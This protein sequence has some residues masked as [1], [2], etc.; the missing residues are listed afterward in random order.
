MDTTVLDM[1]AENM[2]GGSARVGLDQLLAIFGPNY[3]K[4]AQDWALTHNMRFQFYA[5]KSGYAV[6]TTEN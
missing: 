6:L 2:D 5:G 3:E 4:T 1:I